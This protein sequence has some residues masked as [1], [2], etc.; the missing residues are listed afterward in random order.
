MIVRTFSLYVGHGIAGG[1]VLANVVLEFGTI[2]ILLVVCKA[3]V[4]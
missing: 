3:S 1:K 2:H 4:T